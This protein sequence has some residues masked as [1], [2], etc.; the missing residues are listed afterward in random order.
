MCSDKSQFI[1]TTNI[2]VIDVF[3]FISLPITVVHYFRAA[4]ISYYYFSRLL[5]LPLK[6]Y[7]VYPQSIVC[8]KFSNLS[9]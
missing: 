5:R 6:P 9:N 8:A 7:M 3:R 2:V 1:S 4:M